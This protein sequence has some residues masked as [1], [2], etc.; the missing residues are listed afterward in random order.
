MPIMSP[1]QSLGIDYK[2]LN[3]KGIPFHHFQKKGAPLYI[4]IMIR[5]GSRYDEK[6]GTAHFLEHMLCASTKKFP[7]K[8]LLAEYIE[9]IGGM[10]S[11]ST[12]NEFI[13]INVEVAEEKDLVAAITVI[14]EMINKPL[15][16][17]KTL[18]NERGS[19]LSE[20]A[21]RKANQKEF[22]WTVCRRLFFQKTDME[23]STLGNPDS[24]KSISVDD[25]ISFKEK[26]FTCENIKVISAGDID[27]KNISNELEK[28]LP[29]FAEQKREKHLQ[30]P[31]IRDK[32]FDIEIYPSHQASILVG[33]RTNV[34]TVKDQISADICANYLGDGRSS[35]LSKEL[36]YKRGLVYGA[37]S[38]TQNYE[39]GSAF[40]VRTDCEVEKYET[41]ISTINL[42]LENFKKEGISGDKLSNVKSKIIKSSIIKLQTSETIVLRSDRIAATFN[43]HSIDSY[44][45]RLKEITPKDI[46]T[47]IDDNLKDECRYIAV[48]GPESIYSL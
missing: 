12:D 31:I 3:H 15:F 33:F 45:S 14:D 10:F 20:Y 40:G 13:K 39:D 18:E 23:K 22:L 16:E 35:L 43:E 29:T 30:L 26:Y 42:V 37:S 27:I 48:C 11:L 6:S 7:S 28:V 46:K 34:I 47:Y 8:D 5:A 2:S 44:L 36:R 19:I 17:P 9:N 41:V 32:D 38:F 21:G 25:L 4:R 24:I 1:L